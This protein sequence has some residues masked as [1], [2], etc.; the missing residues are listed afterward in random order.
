[1]FC[2]T[3][4][5]SGCAPAKPS[6]GG[7]DAGSPSSVSTSG[8]PEGTSSVSST[9]VAT[10]AAAGPPGTSSLPQPFS[11]SVYTADQ[12]Q[13]YLEL[14]HNDY[15]YMTATTTGG[16]QYSDDQLL[17][18]G[19]EGCHVGSLTTPERITYIQEHYLTVDA[20]EFREGWTTA[21]RRWAL[22]YA[23]QVLCPQYDDN[24]TNVVG[25]M[26]VAGL[27]NAGKQLRLAQP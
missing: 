14:E 20:K 26:N 7:M 3:L 13:R 12:I 17:Q 22:I 18:Y 16:K 1:M 9:A 27:G 15:D 8:D 10:H 21:V 5:G 6:A 24:I 19:A 23:T 11:T 4:L 2:I 25:D